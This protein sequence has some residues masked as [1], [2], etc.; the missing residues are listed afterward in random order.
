MVENSNVETIDQHY[1][2]RFY[3]KNFSEIKGS[4][5]KEKVL[6]TFYQFNGSLIKENIPVKSICYEEYFYGLDGEVEKDL[7]KKE[8]TWAKTIQKKLINTDENFDQE[9]VRVIKQFAVY[10]YCRTLASYNYNKDLLSEM[11]AEFICPKVPSISKEIV[12]K[13]VENRI[14]NETNGSDLVYS[15][16]ELTQE[17]ED[18]DIGLIRYNTERKLITSDMPVIVINPF[19]QDMIG[20]S[21]AGIVIFFPLS[22]ELLVVF[23]DNKIYNNIKRYMVVNNEQEVLNLNKYQVLSAEERIIS[24][25]REELSLLVSDEVLVKRRDERISEEKID[26]SF[27]GNE[28]FV[29]TKSRVVTYDYELS[30]CKLPKYL[31]KIPNDCRLVYN[32]KF[33]YDARKSLLVGAYVIPNLIAQNPAYGKI[34]VSKLR[35]GYLKMQQFMDDYW[36]VPK[37]DRT[38]TPELMRELKSTRLSYYPVR[39]Y[40][41]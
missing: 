21:N 30:F 20:F 13:L 1:V 38:I 41:E 8:L 22:P 15:C 19:C 27:D 18:L 11:Y 3:L 9:S 28:T 10:Q 39:D 6:T 24:K 32:R 26:S 23:Y 37:E 36:N 7:A 17:I 29:A 31:R 4:G 2:P 12:K 16:D 25:Y 5:K 40:I 33:N 14:E 34:D 35:D